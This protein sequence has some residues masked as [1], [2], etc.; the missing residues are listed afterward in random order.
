M[1][2]LGVGVRLGIATIIEFLCSRVSAF[3]YRELATLSRI[4]FQRFVRFAASIL[5]TM[6]FRF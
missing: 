4:P 2:A 3:I 6:G 5:D 1:A